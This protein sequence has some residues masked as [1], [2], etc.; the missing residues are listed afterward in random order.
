MIM[1][2]TAHIILT[3]LS[4]SLL[5]SCRGLPGRD[6]IDG[7]GVID[8]VVVNVPQSA[9]QYTNMD[10]NNYFFA[11]VEMPEIT[12]TAFQKGLVKMYRCYDFNA[13]SGKGTKMELPYVRLNEEYIAADDFWAFYTETVDYEYS[14]GSVTVF[15]TVSDF[16]YEIDESFVPEAMQFQCV[17]MY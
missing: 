9:W 2:K 3:A 10:N 12:R 5:S 7:L 13:E 11:T 15:Y 17:V 4:I 8:N 14:V 6:G 16:N 1:K